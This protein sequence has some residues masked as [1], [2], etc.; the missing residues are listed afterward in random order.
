ALGDRWSPIAVPVAAAIVTGLFSASVSPEAK[1]WQAPASLAELTALTPQGAVLGCLLYLSVALWCMVRFGRSL[2]L[3]ANL[4]LLATPYLFNLLLALAA[5]G[6]T[7]GLGRTVLGAGLPDAIAS[8]L[9]RTMILFAFNEALLLGLGLLMDRRWTRSWR[10]HLLVLGSSA[11]A[12]FTPVVADLG[13]TET[14]SRWAVVARLGPMVLTG[15]LAQAGLWAQV[16]LVTGMLLDTLRGRRPTW[17]AG[18]GHWYAG[19]VRGAVYG[20]LFVLL[21]QL[22]ALIWG[23]PAVVGWLRSYP[24]LGGALLGLLLFPLAKTILESFD[25]SA[26]FFARFAGAMREPINYLRGLIC[27]LGLGLALAHDLPTL[28]GGLRFALG[29]VIGAAAYA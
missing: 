8:G 7:L 15:A 27:G 19:A 29:F 10:L 14:L 17:A 12:A 24:V 22:G 28:S 3:I 1:L 26:P 6:I 13:S 5:H 20:G 11:L 25:G 9:G 23:S 16:F 18:Y 2:S 4:S 21:V